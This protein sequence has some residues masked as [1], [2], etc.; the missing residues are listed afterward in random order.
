[1][2]R[3][4]LSAAVDR[5][6][7]KLDRDAARRAAQVAND[8]FVDVTTDEPGMAWLDGSVF[9]TDG[10]ALDRRLDALA[11]TVCDGD[12][13]TCK[14][15]R[16]D[17]LGALA[18]GSDR[19]VCGCGKAE[20][21]AAVPAPKSNVAIHVVAEQTTVEGTGTTPRAVPGVEGLIPAEL[22]A[23]LAKSA[24]LLPLSWPTGAEPGY[25][26]ST[27]LA[28]FVRGRDLTCRVPGAVGPP[29]TAT[30][31]TPRPLRRRRCHPPIEPECLCRLQHYI[32]RLQTGPIL[33]A[34]PDRSLPVRKGHRAQTVDAPAVT[35]NADQFGVF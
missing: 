27:K 18:A 28:D 3:G 8:R 35:G 10:Q 1:M 11:A 7:A 29:P 17:A 12:P 30:S 9:A 15:R 4:R 26:P 6:V 16:A 21:G 2:T 25:P 14:Q 23:E 31:T 33:D 34:L 32:K 22:V 24:R 19:L 20:C 5:V 13:R